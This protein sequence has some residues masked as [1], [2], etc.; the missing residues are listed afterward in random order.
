[1]DPNLRS[2]AVFINSNASVLRTTQKSKVNIPFNGNLSV[3]DP[4]KML[5]VALSQMKFTNS[6][7]N[8]TKDNNLE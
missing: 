5:R 3:Q 6:V 2:F 1:M 7:Y 4:H 8:I